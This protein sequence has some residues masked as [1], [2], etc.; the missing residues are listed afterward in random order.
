MSLMAER[1]S[2][3]GWLARLMDEFRLNLSRPDALLQ[4]AI[5]G[6]AS[7]LLAGGVIIAFRLL[8]EGLQAHFLPGNSTENYEA[9]PV[10]IRFALPVA[11]AALIALF[12]ATFAKDQKVVGVVH[13]ME[14]LAYHQGY[15]T[16][17][18]LVIQF[19]T[20]GIAIVSGHSVGREGPGI[21]LGA[22]ASSLLGQKLALPNNS[23]RTLVGCGTAAAIA[24]SFNTPLAGV[25]FALEVV[26]LDYSLASFTP[27]IL[28]AVSATTLS[29]AVFGS[30]TSFIVP[31]MELSSLLELPLALVLGVLSGLVASLFIA[32]IKL[33]ATRSAN[34]S[35]SLKLILAGGLVG[36]CAIPAP[37]IMGIGYDTVGSALRGELGIGMLVGIVAFKLIA[38]AGSVGLGVPAGLIGPTLFIGACLGA[39]TG[40]IAQYFYPGLLSHSG[41]Y[42]LLG[43]GAMMGA[44]LQAPLAALVAIFELTGN[45]G[46]ILP[47][48]LTIIAASLTSRELFGHRS[49]FLDLLRLR[50]LDYRNDPAMHTLRGTGVANVMDRQ[51]SQHDQ[52]ISKTD[53]RALLAREPIW[54]LIDVDGKPHSLMPAVD[55]ARAVEDSEEE[56]LD[57]LSIPAGRLEVSPIDLRATL[58]EA[59]RLFSENQIEAAYVQRI[60]APGVVRVLGI[61]TRGSIEPAYRT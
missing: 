21:H 48:M 1:W 56:E 12:F 37:E 2:L 42:A 35:F 49:V 57:L 16:L 53:A 54:V 46:I 20:A 58:Q 38:T 30:D 44:T 34:L 40:L 7:G 51:L 45:P 17:R 36:V 22:A 26:M 59:H 27:I 8:F 24:A 60:V 18:G 31:A 14:R 41:V 19:V 39:L 50:G 15:L 3:G 25:I 13:V 29:R 10:A 11:G 61:L 6:V 5:L 32:L 43:M 28:A 47:G 33:S 55:L 52:L 4:L 23:I 9:L